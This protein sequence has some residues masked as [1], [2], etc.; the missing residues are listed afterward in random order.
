MI[1]WSKRKWVTAEEQHFQEVIF[2]ARDD[3]WEFQ[4]VQEEEGDSMK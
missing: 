3:E 4:G 2:Q 1:D